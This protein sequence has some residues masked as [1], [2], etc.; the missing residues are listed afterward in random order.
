RIQL[1]VIDQSIIP[2]GIRYSL[3]V[4]LLDTIR[5]TCRWSSE[6]PKGFRSIILR[7]L[8]VHHRKFGAAT[9]PDTCQWDSA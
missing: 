5:Y 6:F 7:C 8:K 9:T 1:N 4:I 3:T 2:R